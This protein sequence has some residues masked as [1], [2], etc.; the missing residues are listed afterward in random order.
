M[1][2]YSVNRSPFGTRVRAAAAFKAV[3]LEMLGPP[4]GGLKEPAY[5]SL[6]P[7]G[8]LPTLVLDDGS[9]VPESQVIVDL[10]EDAAPSPSLYPGDVLA[11]SRARLIP[12]LVDLYVLPPLFELFAHMDPAR[13]DE[14][15]ASSIFTRFGAGLD[16][17][18]VY[19]ADQGFAVC[20]TFSAADCALAPALFWVDTVERLFA[21]ATPGTRPKMAAYSRMAKADALLGPLLVDMGTD[22]ATVMG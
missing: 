3:A 21:R 20:G 18:E 5:L 10:L 7:L 14:R 17:V 11:R 19:L 12:R 1:Q 8:K 6:N 9:A 22:L 13:R 16:A 2:L 15:A 4:A